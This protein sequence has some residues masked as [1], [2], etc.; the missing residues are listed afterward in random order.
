MQSMGKMTSLLPAL[1]SMLMVCTSVSVSACDLSCWLRQTSSDCHS[2]NSAMENGAETMSVSSVMDMS[3]EMKISSHGAQNKA[4]L[5]QSTKGVAGHQMSAQMDMVGSALQAINEIDATS[6]TRF[7]H[8]R[9]LSSCSH[10]AC[11][12]ATA[13]VSPPSASQN[14]S[15]YL[16]CAIL[17]LSSATNLVINSRQ[18]ARGSPPLNQHSADPL[19]TLRV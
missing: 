10:E 7:D 4:G 15:A 11:S 6:S 9:A 18:L 17:D 2:G 8:S 12:Q 5:G 3:A 16:H 1:L 19:P 14:Q 13:S